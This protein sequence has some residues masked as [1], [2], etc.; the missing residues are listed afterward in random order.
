VVKSTLSF[1]NMSAAGQKEERKEA[2][3]EGKREQEAS[4]ASVEGRSQ[5]LNLFKAV[6][7]RNPLYWQCIFYITPNNE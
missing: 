5:P 6:W 3:E 7:V 2:R 1:A 4:Q